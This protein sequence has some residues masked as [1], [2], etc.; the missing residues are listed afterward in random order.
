VE[1]LSGDKEIY[2]IKKGYPDGCPA[3]GETRMQRRLYLS[4]F[5]LFELFEHCDV[6]QSK[7]KFKFSKLSSLQS[8]KGFSQQSTKSFS[9]QSTKCFSQQSSKFSSQ[10]FHHDPAC[11][12]GPSS[13]EV[14][15]ETPQEEFSPI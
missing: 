10:Q 14:T 15:P 8:T 11:C 12:D 9:Q 2:F 13:G 3:L 4:I 6:S 1:C 5:E 7:G